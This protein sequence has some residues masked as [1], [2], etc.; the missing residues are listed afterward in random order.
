MMFDFEKNNLSSMQTSRLKSI[1]PFGLVLSI[2]GPG[3]M[4]EGVLKRN[5]IV[6]NGLKQVDL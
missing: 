4:A 1:N 3:S 5:Q 2:L 6:F